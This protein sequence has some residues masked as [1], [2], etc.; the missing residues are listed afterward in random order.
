[1]QVLEQFSVAFEAAPGATLITD[2]DGIIVFT[3]RAL[4]R[5]FEYD[6]GELTGQTVEVLIPHDLRST[7]PELR[8]AYL[9][10]PT[11]RAMGSG[12]NLFG[13]SRS[14]GP[15]PIEIGLNHVDTEDGTFVIASVLDLRM[16][17]KEE[18]KTRLAIDAAA[19][20]MIM[21]DDKGVIVLANTQCEEMF[22]YSTAELIGSAIES[23][24]PTTQR[25]KHSVY[26]MSYASAPSKRTMGRGRDLNGCRKDGTEF[27]IEIGLTPIDNHGERL[28][29]AT[30]IDITERKIAEADLTQKNKDLNRLNSELTQFA[31]SASHD[32]KAP[33]SSIEGLLT[34]IEVDLEDHDLDAVRQNTAHA[35][36]MTE[37]LKTLIEDILGLARAEHLDEDHCSVCVTSV[38]DDALKH[39]QPEAMKGNVELTSNVEPDLHIQT[40]PTRIRQVVENLIQ[41]S[42]KYSDNSKP[43]SFVRVDAT[44][45]NSAMTLKIQDN[46]IGIPTHE[47]DNVFKLFKRYDNHELSGSGLGLALVKQHID[48]LDGNIEFESNRHG[49]LF[50]IRIPVF[51]AGVA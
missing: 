44:L 25:K 27:P 4:D 5:L 32:L 10:V 15:I 46:G 39:V 40:Q 45:T 17:K 41:N 28:I 11:S 49:T 34:C 22:G 13:L 35:K 12:R 16:R 21:A 3:N 48:Q 30:I 7:H 19:S 43:S 29:M 42:V 38:V 50:T 1:M 2:A 31:Y 37:R 20:A 24:V 18:E 36:K 8:D 6:D 14:G 9:E 51:A 26:R 47:H 23:L 33:L